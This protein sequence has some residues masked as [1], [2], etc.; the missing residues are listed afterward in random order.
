VGACDLRSHSHCEDKTVSELRS[1]DGKY[2]SI[3]SHRS[4]VNGAS[5]TV[6][7]V[8]ENTLVFADSEYV[9]IVDGIYGVTGSWKDPTHLEISSEAFQDQKKVITQATSWETVVISYK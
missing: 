8:Q 9:L 7:S 3:L 4:C 5:Y 1:P 6:V 2:T